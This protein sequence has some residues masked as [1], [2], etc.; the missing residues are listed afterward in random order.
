[1]PKSSSSA[2][3]IHRPAYVCWHFMKHKCSVDLLL[4]HLAALADWTGKSCFPENYSHCWSNFLWQSLVLSVMFVW[5]L[6]SS[7]LFIFHHK[8]SGNICNILY[9][10]ICKM[11]YIYTVSYMDRL[12]WDYFSL[13]L[14]ALVRSSWAGSRQA[15]SP[16]KHSRMWSTSAHLPTVSI[17][18]SKP[19]RRTITMFS[20]AC[21]L[22]C[23]FCSSEIKKV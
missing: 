5:F 8:M 19:P 14:E 20:K 12:C 21:P 6:W 15:A 17:N 10:Q 22:G 3:Y 11:Y 9:E 13:T 7:L 4:L 1:M 16:M 2:K 18:N 23:R